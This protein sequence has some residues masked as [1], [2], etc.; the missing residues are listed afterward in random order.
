MHRLVLLLVS[1]ALL[2]FAPVPHF[3]PMTD[4]DR[5]IQQFESNALANHTRNESTIAD[6]KRRLVDR[7]KD[8]HQSLLARGKNR[9][10]EAVRERLLLVE[11][12]DA[13]RPLGS[14]DKP[15]VLLEK[16]GVRGKYRHLLHVVYAPADRGIYSGFNDFGFWNGTS[17]LT[18]GDL[19]SGYWVYVHP[20][21]FVW[22][23]GPPPLP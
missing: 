21:W 18:Q 1:P 11:S 17:Y 4:P 15:V 12:M 5:A 13:E 6:R 3:K 9:E 8:L 14:T 7:M 10:A 2:A 19:K 16:A 22:R 23:D 20:R